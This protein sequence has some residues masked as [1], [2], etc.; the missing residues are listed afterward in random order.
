MELRVP[1]I[2]PEDAKKAVRLYE[3]GLTIRQVVEQIGYS[4]GTIHRVLHKHGVAMRA[5]AVGKGIGDVSSR[6]R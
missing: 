1:G 6:D 3:P 4:F 2:T 5:S